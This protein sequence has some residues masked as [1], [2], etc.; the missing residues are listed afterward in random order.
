M[1]CLIMTNAKPMHYL[2]RRRGCLCPLSA[3]VCLAPSHV[4]TS[5]SAGRGDWPDKP[6]LRCRYPGVIGIPGPWQGLRPV[7]TAESAALWC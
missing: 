3:G 6:S 5:L 1:H 2:G 7:L 4:I